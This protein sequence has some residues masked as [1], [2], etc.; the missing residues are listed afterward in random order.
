[1]STADHQTDDGALSTGWS[2][3]CGSTAAGIGFYTGNQPLIV[4]ALSVTAA[5]LV[6]RVAI[7]VLNRQRR[8]T[9]VVEPRRW[10]A[11]K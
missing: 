4:V 6:R 11:T 8:T 5:D 10:H 9:V 1:M 2:V 7:Q 3:L